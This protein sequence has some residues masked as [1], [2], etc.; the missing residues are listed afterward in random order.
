MK[1]KLIFT[2]LIVPSTTNPRREF[3]S[4]ADKEL[5]ASIQEKGV[6]EALLVRE[7]PNTNGQ[8]A[9]YELVDGERRWRAAM[10][11]GLEEVPAEICDMTDEEAQEYQM[12]SFVRENLKP[13]EEAEL[14]GRWAKLN[15]DVPAIAKKC[16]RTPERVAKTMVLL[17]LTSAWKKYFVENH[18]NFTEAMAIARMTHAQQ[19]EF[20]T[21][22]RYRYNLGTG[23]PDTKEFLKDIEAMFH[24]QLD[25]Y[26][27][28]KTD[29]LLVKSAGSCELCPKCSANNLNLFGDL[30]KSVICTD[31]QCVKAKMKAYR[32]RQ[33][34]ML[35]R[36][37]DPFVLITKEPYTRKS[38]VLQRSDWSKAKEGDPGTVKAMVWDGDQRG[39][40]LTVKPKKMPKETPKADPEQQAAKQEKDEKKEKIENVKRDIAIEIVRTLCNRLLELIARRVPKVLDKTT[41]EE[42]YSVLDNAFYSSYSAEKLL[43]IKGKI[44]NQKLAVAIQL[45]NM[46]AILYQVD[47]FMN[48]DDADAVV[49]LEKKAKSLGIDTK[50]VENAVRAEVEQQ[51]A[52]ELAELTKKPNK[53]DKP[54]SKTKVRKTKGK[55]SK[56]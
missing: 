49:Y 10:A 39:Q 32:E 23:Q 52:A 12:I 55:K 28:D 20:L 17:N 43:G 16:S 29:P 9:K 6:I 15:Y 44:E 47:D 54:V 11:V 21:M 45:L 34:R 36:S 3:D 13:M 30:G 25:K 46:K 51:H 37:G 50:Q 1:H 41:I 14:Y 42:L 56:K 33:H 31:I 8:Q 26:A 22:R 4:P 35:Q 38:D 53:T 24:C 2:T 40:I 18:I 19:E 7:H 27:F 5:A 48:G